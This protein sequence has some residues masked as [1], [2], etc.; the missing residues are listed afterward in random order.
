MRSLRGLGGPGCCEPGRLAVHERVGSE[1]HLVKGPIITG[2][3]F[4][5]VAVVKDLH[6]TTARLVE[7][8]VRFGAPFDG[9]R[10]LPVGP[11]G[12]QVSLQIEQQIFPELVAQ[13]LI[14]GLA[15]GASVSLMKLLW[16]R[17]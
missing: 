14:A 9:A 8:W 3:A 5:I 16:R 1:W 6:E 7:Q 11:I 2:S 13:G 15:D 10:L 12:N 4:P 17:N